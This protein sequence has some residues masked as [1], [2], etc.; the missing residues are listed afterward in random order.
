[1]ALSLMIEEDKRNERDTPFPGIDL[2]EIV[3]EEDA[4][5][6][7]RALVPFDPL[8]RYLTEIRRF[9]LRLHFRRDPDR[10][11]CR[12]REFDLFSSLL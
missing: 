10:T 1:M 2:P 8:Q 5:T 12:A 3:T 4:A 6:R 11:P 7:D 9:P